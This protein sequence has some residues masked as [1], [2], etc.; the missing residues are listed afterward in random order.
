MFSPYFFM[1][2]FFNKTLI[3]ST[4][5]IAFPFEL[6]TTLI[7]ETSVIDASICCKTDRP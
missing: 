7:G 3:I 6:G 2:E 5:L 1:S 4:S